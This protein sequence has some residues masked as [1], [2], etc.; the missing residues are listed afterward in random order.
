MDHFAYRG[1]E[2]WCEDVRLAELIEAVGTPAW[3]YSRATL[4]DHFRRFRDAF[5]ALNPTICFSLKALANLHV[6]RVLAGE[7]SGFD[8]TSGGEMVRAL[9][10][11]GEPEKIVYAG[12]GKTDAEIRLGLE[13]GIGAFNVESEA[14][15]ENLSRL[16]GQVGRRPVAALRVNPDV[17]DPKT[18]AYTLTGKKETKF[19]VDID[20]AER[21]FQTF[22]ADPNVRLEGLHIHLGSPIYSPA[23]YVSALERVLELIDRLRA[24]GHEI[25]LLDVGGGFASDYDVDRSPRAE[26]YARAIVP[27]LEREDLR[28]VLEPGRSISANAGVLVSR[29][30]YLKRGGEKTFVIV[31]AAMSDLIRPALY[32]GEHF[33][34]P[35]APSDGSEPRREMSFA[36]PE[37]VKVD[38]VGGVCESSDFLGTDRV[39]PRL[40]RG[41]LLG[42]FSAGAYGMTMSSNYNTRPRGP[43]VLVEGDAWRVVRRRETYDDLLA[44]ERE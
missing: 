39:L 8:V 9:E 7:G 44:P 20:R 1:G 4:V 32:G 12:V 18:H 17:Y 22:G 16:A 43:E 34:Y 35:L 30:Q 33:I 2:L 11:G 24:A 19:G 3:V 31:D 28:V 23:P 27:L 13:R 38:V 6:L 37:G 10:A 41:D 21:F 26:E 29:V 5:A 25:G 40:S 15:F 42:V 36:A 14:E